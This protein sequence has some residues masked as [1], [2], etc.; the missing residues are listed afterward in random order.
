MGCG[1]FSDRIYC[2][3][4]FFLWFP[5]DRFLSTQRWEITEL[6]KYDFCSHSLFV[7]SRRQFL[8]T[9][10]RWSF[11]ACFS[12][13]DF[14]SLLVDVN[15]IWMRT[16]RKHCKRRKQKRL[17][18]KKNKRKKKND[19]NNRNAIHQLKN[20]RQNCA[21]RSSSTHTKSHRKKSKRT[22]KQATT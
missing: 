14:V 20:D 21:N 10:D 22:R 2:D 19:Q 18:E 13:E 17:E 3:T 7:T 8:M 9:T 12:F 4:Y 15:N 6:T 16:R 11:P 1:Q 5:S